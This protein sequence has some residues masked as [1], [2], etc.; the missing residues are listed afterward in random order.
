MGFALEI[1]DPKNNGVEELKTH[2][3]GIR[4]GAALDMKTFDPGTQNSAN[5]EALRKFLHQ[6]TSTTINIHE[7]LSTSAKTTGDWMLNDAAQQDATKHGGASRIHDRQ[8]TAISII[9]ISI[10]IIIIN[11]I[12]IIIII[13]ISSSRMTINMIIMNYYYCHDH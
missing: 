11:I 3:E 5:T 6:N 2:K 12:I 1:A 4:E 8:R 13:I 7:H 9:I 10:I